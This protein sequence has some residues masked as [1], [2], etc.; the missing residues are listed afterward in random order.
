MEALTKE[1]RYEVLRE[2]L[3]ERYQAAHLIRERGTQFTLWISGMGIGLAWL[4]IQEVELGLTQKISMTGFVFALAVA[5]WIL[6]KAQAQGLSN[7]L[8]RQ[9]RLE[10]ALGLFSKGPDGTMEPILPESYK[11]AG[12]RSP[13][14]KHYKGLVVWLILLV[15]SLVSLTWACPTPI[16]ESSQV[17]GSPTQVEGGR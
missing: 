8:Q 11:K 14:T 13:W 12:R 5:A 3:T 17:T 4:L 16:E 9:A 2:Q 10:E 1:Q 7:T 15:I 6:L